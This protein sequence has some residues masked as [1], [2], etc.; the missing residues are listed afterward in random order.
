MAQLH[1][2]YYNGSLV[3]PQLRICFY[4]FSLSYIRK[5]EL[6]IYIFVSRQYVIAYNIELFYWLFFAATLMCT[7][8]HSNLSDGWSLHCHDT[9]HC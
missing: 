9:Y 8:E 7:A 1:G 5:G 3:I 6:A 4:S 2:P